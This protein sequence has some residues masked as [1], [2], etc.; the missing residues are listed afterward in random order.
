MD[1][2]ARLGGGPESRE[3]RDEKMGDILEA[4]GV[5]RSKVE[6][7]MTLRGK[8]AIKGSRTMVE[9]WFDPTIQ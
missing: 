4:S 1:E 2:H 6:E 7:A 5:S 3:K 8:G 9:S